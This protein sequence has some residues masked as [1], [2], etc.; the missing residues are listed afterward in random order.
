[1]AGWRCGRPTRCRRS[2]R[3]ATRSSPG[4]RSSPVRSPS[5]GRTTT[6]RCCRS[7][8]IRR[9][10]RWR[11]RARQPTPRRRRLPRRSAWSR[12]RTTT[13]D[14]APGSAAT[15]TTTTCPRRAIADIVSYDSSIGDEHDRRAAAIR[16]RAQ[17]ARRR[18]HVDRLPPRRPHR[19]L[20][21]QPQHLRLSHL[22]VDQRARAPAQ[23]GLGRLRLGEF[24]R[25]LRVRRSQRFRP[26][27]GVAHPDP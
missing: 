25:A 24:P 6:S 9:C 16:A 23:G 21:Q 27:R 19:R 3:R 2:A 11:C 26:G 15:A 4:V 10:R 18:R 13:G 1:M 20:H 8:S 7:R 14:S 12:A 22:R 17:Y 5:A